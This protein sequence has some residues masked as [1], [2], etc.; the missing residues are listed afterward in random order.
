MSQLKLIKLVASREFFLRLKS[1]AF[2]GSMTITTLI[3]LAI[4]VIPSLAK[5]DG[6]STVELGIVAG[7]A[8]RLQAAV[9]QAPTERQVEFIEFES[10]ST[11]TTGLRNGEVDA[12][13]A[14]DNDIIVNQGGFLD[15]YDVPSVVL[16][17]AQILN[18]QDAS[19][20]SGLSMQELAEL[21]QPSLNVEVLDEKDFDKVRT[22]IAYIGMMVTYMAILMFGAWTMTGVMEEKSSKV[23]ETIVSTLRPRYLLAGKVIGI[24]GLAFVQIGVLFLTAAL[25]VRFTGVLDDLGGLPIDSLVML[26]IWFVVGFAFYNTLFAATGALV[27]QIDDAQVANMPLSLIAVGSMMVSY[28]ALNDADSAIA[29]IATYVPLSAPFVVPIRFAL[30]SIEIWEVAL[31]LVVTIG[32]AVL[33]II[34]AGRIYEGALLRSGGRVK[35]REAWRGDR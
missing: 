26:G 5:D 22:L 32:F 35:L 1:K 3:L 33:A 7:K 16:V 15:V 19:I 31:A 17:G 4:I 20:D 2:L 34:G 18:L 24:G 29:R 12:V 13:L 27:N 25:A 21:T 23:V 28:A 14:A 6:P 10:L 8:E 9:G 30:E 11:A